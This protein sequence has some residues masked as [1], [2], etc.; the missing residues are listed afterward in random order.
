MRSNKP[1]HS[2]FLESRQQ[3]QELENLQRVFVRL[4]KNNDKKI[5]PDELFDYLKKDLSYKCG[6]A[7]VEDMLWEV[8]EDC[9]GGVDWEEFKS[10]CACAP[11]APCT[12]CHAIHCAACRTLL[13]LALSFLWRSRS[14]VHAHSCR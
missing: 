4:D 14:Q 12:L 6:R 8:D 7:A 1:D 11:L 2:E 3:K 10:M 9:D 13:L 5:T